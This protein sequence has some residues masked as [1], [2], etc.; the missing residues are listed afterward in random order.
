MMYNIISSISSNFPIVSTLVWEIEILYFGNWKLS[1]LMFPCCVC[2]QKS[3]S[4]YYFLSFVDPLLSVVFTPTILCVLYFPWWPFVLVENYHVMFYLTEIG[5][6]GPIIFYILLS[7]FFYHIDVV[8][9]VHNVC[10]FLR[11]TRLFSSF[12]KEIH[13][14]KMFCDFC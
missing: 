10:N 9:I 7:R 3:V 13:L 8:D 1:F 6:I 2:M 12:F 11:K 4:Q 5:S 14:K